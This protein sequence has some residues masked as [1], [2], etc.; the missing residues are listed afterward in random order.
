M[1]NFRV[2]F[3]IVG[4]IC[5]LYGCEDPSLVGTDF[6]GEN[7]ITV[8]YYDTVS[9]QISTIKFDSLA[10]SNIS[11]LLVG[12]SEDEQLGTVL[13]APFFQVGRDLLNSYPDDEKATFDSLTLELSF[14]GYSYYDTTQV[15][16]YNLY[17]L[18]AEMELGD[19][20]KLYNTTNYNY[21]Q[22]SVYHLGEI[23]FTPRVKKG[24]EEY[25]RINDEF[26]QA[27]FELLQQKDDIVTNSDDFSS[28]IK[29]FVLV[30][31]SANTCIIGLNNE[32][33]FKL[34]YQQDG[35]QVE[36]EF[37][38]ADNIHFTKISV[39]GSDTIQS[40]LATQRDIMKSNELGG[41]AFIQAGIGLAMRVEFPYLDYIRELSKNNLVTDAELI[42]SPVKDS[43]SGLHPLSTNLTA[44]RV[45]K[46]NNVLSSFTIDPILYY[47]DEYNEETY[48][49]INI[50][51]YLEEQL[52]LLE[53][54][55][56]A[57]LIALDQDTYSST[58][59]RIYIGDEH[60]ESKSYMKLLVMNIN[61]T[62]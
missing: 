1:G 19:D 17:S 12:K 29:G 26:G 62:F 45:D 59:N 4:F 6:V 35:D 39:Q 42:L 41:L 3:I 38:I 5:A 7:P 43:Y 55:G 20:G 25:L 21:I 9:I 33:N 32:T 48:Y 54:D 56:S 50:A 52:D 23:S 40:Q 2:G 34:F 31:D 22:D 60:N 28:Y 57:L 47:D 10:T 44:Y 11:R 27:L 53:N 13:A 36:L 8:T 16:T 61:E 15:Q 14:D 18:L 46:Y 24:K 51:S 49:S 30:P 37:P 58:L